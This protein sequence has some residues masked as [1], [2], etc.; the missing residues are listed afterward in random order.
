[1]KY[2]FLMQIYGFIWFRLND[3]AV[4]FDTDVFYVLIV[5]FG[6]LTK[7]ANYYYLRYDK[8]RKMNEELYE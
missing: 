8:K 6:K 5:K 2:Y 1:M 3:I 7:A 4:F